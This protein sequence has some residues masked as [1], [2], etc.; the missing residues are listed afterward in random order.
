MQL[1][2]QK[3]TIQSDWKSSICFPGILSFLAKQTNCVTVL[4]ITAITL[5]LLNKHA[6]KRA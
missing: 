6:E 5:H 4:T 3:S 2:P 1:M